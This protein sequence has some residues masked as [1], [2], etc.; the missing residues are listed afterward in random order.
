MSKSD[1]LETEA[2]PWPDSLDA[3]V[4]A[5]ANHIKL[6][7]NDRV[8]VLHTVIPPEIIMPRIPIVAEAGLT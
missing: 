6:L 7:E 2:W 5:P 1:T 4:A 8:R 3:Q